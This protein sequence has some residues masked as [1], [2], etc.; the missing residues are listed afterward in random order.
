MGCRAIETG[1]INAVAPGL[2]TVFITG[3]TGYIGQALGAAL[4]ARGHTLR[5]LVRRGSEARLP[6]GATA[7]IGDALDPDSYAHTV[8]PADTFVHLVGT[9]HPNPAKLRQFREVD[10]ASIKAAVAAA[11]KSASVRHMIYVSVAQPA[12]VMRAYVEVRKEGERLIRASG[13]NATLIRPWYV[14]G[15]GRRWPVVLRPLYALMR[16]LPATRDMA[17]RLG[18]VTL[19]QMVEVLVNAVESEP[20]GVRVVDVP[21]IVGGKL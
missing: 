10:L 2:R 11:S 14:L 7:I 17:I 15:P 4:L 12:P 20:R 18:L 21:G 1:S 16:R 13:L 9:P 3:A 8:S 5:A 6:Y 19:A